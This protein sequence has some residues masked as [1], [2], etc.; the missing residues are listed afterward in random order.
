M[1]MRDWE[2]VCVG[3]DDER[4]RVLA[5]KGTP[6]VLWERI[7]LMMMAACTLTLLPRVKTPTDSRHHH[8][9]SFSSLSFI[10]SLLPTASIHHTSNHAS[11]WNK[12]SFIAHTCPLPS[13][14]LY[15]SCIYHFCFTC[16][17]TAVLVYGYLLVRKASSIPLVEWTPLPPNITHPVG[18]TAE[19]TWSLSGS[20][21]GQTAE[22]S[23]EGD[24]SLSG[25]PLPNPII[26]SG[27]RVTLLFSNWVWNWDWSRHF[28]SN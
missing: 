25:Y 7:W 15:P 14:Y 18:Q 27:I 13:L 1:M 11:S 26:N 28:W 22:I 3:D 12:L 19:I 21:V 8:L 16:M 5:G 20:F 9:L 24:N 17:W 10:S 4:L 2:V 6:F 23:V